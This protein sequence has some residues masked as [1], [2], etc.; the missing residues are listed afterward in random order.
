MRTRRSAVHYV[1]WLNPGLGVR[2]GFG[3]S[4]ITPSA[5]FKAAGAIFAVDF[6]HVL[7]WK[8]ASSAEM[9]WLDALVERLLQFLCLSFGM[10]SLCFWVSK[11]N[12]GIAANS[13]GCWWT[14]LPVLLP[15]PLSG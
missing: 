2:R 15:S 1:W 13:A 10:P 5:A 6:L 3:L 14:F 4:P 12:C 11:G 9:G 8:I 7:C